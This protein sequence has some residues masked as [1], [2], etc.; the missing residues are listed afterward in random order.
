M[1][2]RVTEGRVTG[3]RSA[4]EGG[5]GEEPGERKRVRTESDNGQGDFR[6]WINLK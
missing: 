1:G 3:Y 2:G 4:W 6:G 5:V